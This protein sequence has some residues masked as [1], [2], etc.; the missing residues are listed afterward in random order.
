MIEYISGN[1]VNEIDGLIVQGVNCQG[2][3]NS[4]LARVIRN[5]WPIV[6]EEYSRIIEFAIDKETLLGD[7]HTILVDYKLV[8]GNIF[9]QVYYGYDSKKYA[10]VSAIERGMTQAI[11]FA[12][13]HS[14]KIKTVRI[15]CGLG[16]LSWDNEVKPIFEKLSQ[17]YNIDIMVFEP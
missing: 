11:L 9:S 8:I 2:K 17:K 7:F 16:G 15:G 14:L 5:K 4:G 13:K 1:I 3:M 12:L 6:F 10:D